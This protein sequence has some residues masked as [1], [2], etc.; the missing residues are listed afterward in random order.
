MRRLAAVACMTLLAACGA[1]IGSGDEKADLADVAIQVPGNGIVFFPANLAA[2]KSSPLRSQTFDPV[3]GVPPLDSLPFDDETRKFLK[4]TVECALRPNQSVR[5]HSDV[6]HGLMG[7]CPSWN[8]RPPNKDCREAVSACLLA[9]QNPMELLIRFSPRGL[10]GE[11]GYFDTTLWANADTYEAD[12]FGTKISS[13]WTSCNG[14]GGE[15]RDCGWP[16]ATAFTGMCTPGASVSVGAGANASDCNNPLGS[17]VL[18]NMVLRVCDGMSGCNAASATHLGSNDDVCGDKHPAVDFTCPQSGVFSAMLGPQK[19]G[20]LF[21]GTVGAKSAELVEFP[22]TLLQLFTRNEATYYGNMFD[23]LN[24]Q[25]HVVSLGP[26]E[27][28]ILQ[29]DPPRGKHT[30]FGSPQVFPFEDA[31][32]CYDP[33]Y[34]PEYFDNGRVCAIQPVLDPAMKPAEANLCLCQ[35]LGPC[36]TVESDSRANLCPVLDQLPFLGDIDHDDCRD[37][38]GVNRRWPMTVFLHD[39]CDM[40]GEEGQGLCKP[41]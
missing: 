26:N 25:V 29:L 32:C 33:D 21:T 7:E 13:F 15:L 39:S 36:N 37:G 19:A 16:A 28:Y 40:V 27:G 41:K 20:Q 1:E 4:Y 30:G 35:S 3:A 38:F 12:Y 6:Y 11:G 8:W 22:A 23:K 17:A 9:R 10:L 5:F 31:W 2:F 14:T 24:P 18:G 34:P